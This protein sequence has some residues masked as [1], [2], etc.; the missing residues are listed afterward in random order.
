[1][2]L[3]GVEAGET[4]RLHELRSLAPGTGALVVR[5]P[6]RISQRGATPDLDVGIVAALPLDLER[7]V[8][9]G[10]AGLLQKSLHLGQ[11]VEPS[12]GT[13]HYQGARDLRT[14]IVSCR[15]VGPSAG[16]QGRSTQRSRRHGTLRRQRVARN[17]S[18]AGGGVGG[19]RRPR[20]RPQR[21]PEQR[22]GW[23]NC[24]T[25]R[26]KARPCGGVFAAWPGVENRG[27]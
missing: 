18:G 15:A 2:Q 19:R 14:K 7:G 1:M 13:R 5:R 20:S 16:A 6:L 22:Q 23:G 17:N 8:E 25:N 27:T 21:H 4:Y 24:A 12:C 26:H 11:A 10:A 3:D 9:V